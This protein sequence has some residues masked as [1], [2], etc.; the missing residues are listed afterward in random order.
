MSNR[1]AD[2]FLSFTACPMTK[3]NLAVVHTTP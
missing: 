3:I 2:D 1:E